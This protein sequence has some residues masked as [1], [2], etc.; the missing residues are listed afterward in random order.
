MD[1]YC[2]KIP[3]LKSANVSLPAIASVGDASCTFRQWAMR[4]SGDP[5]LLSPEE[6]LTK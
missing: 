4:E 3:S 1:G 5:R 2:D 6:V